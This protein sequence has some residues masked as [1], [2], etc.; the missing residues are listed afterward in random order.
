[1][2]TDYYCRGLLAKIITTTPMSNGLNRLAATI[3]SMLPT[4]SAERLDFLGTIAPMREWKGTRQSVRPIE[5]PFTLVNR[6]FET[7]ASLPLDWIKNDKTGNVGQVFGQMGS[8][9]AQWRAKMIADL[10]NNATAGGTYLAFDGLAFFSAS[11]TYGVG[12]SVTVNNISSLTTA[13]GPTKCTPYE[14]AKG[15]VG[16]YQQLIGFLDDRGEPINEDITELAV[17]VPV[18]SGSIMAASAQ[19]AINNPK[20]DTGSGSVDNPVFGLQNVRL[21]LIPS[22]RLTGN[23]AALINVS[24]NA[25]PF[26]FQE[27]LGER[28]MTMKGAGSDFEHDSDA[29][30]MGLKTVGA[31][32]Y[33]RITDACQMAFS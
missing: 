5:Y 15:I 24:P 12:G 32:T 20:L 16:A 3:N 7:S 30:E 10:I 6:K 28:L 25:V 21:S 27:N 14:F 17:V 22:A 4:G 29:W 18:I 26:V 31:A 33:G 23:N 19:Q 8:R 9:M 13:N 11:H 1:V 2:I